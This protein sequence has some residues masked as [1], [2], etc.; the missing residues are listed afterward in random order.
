MKPQKRNRREEPVDQDASSRNIKRKEWAHRVKQIRN[1]EQIDDKGRECMFILMRPD[2]DDMVV[3]A[4]SYNYVKKLEF[5]HDEV[6]G[7]SINSLLS[8]I[9]VEVPC[10][11]CLSWNLVYDREPAT[12]HEKTLSVV[13][14]GVQVKIGDEVLVLACGMETNVLS[15][16]DVEIHQELQTIAASVA[17]QKPFMHWLICEYEESVGLSL[18][19]E[20]SAACVKNTFVSLVDS[21]VNSKEALRKHLSKSTVSYLDLAVVDKEVKL[22][23]QGKVDASET[24]STFS[25]LTHAHA[26]IDP[27][28][29]LSMGSIDHPDNCGK[30]CQFF[31]FSWKGCSKGFQCEY[32]HMP[33]ISNRQMKKQIWI[34]RQQNLRDDQRRFSCNNCSPITEH[35]EADQHSLSQHWQMRMNA[36]S[37]QSNMMQPMG[38]VMQ[39]MGHMMQ[40]LWNPQPMNMMMPYPAYGY[41]AYPIPHMQQ[42]QEADPCLKC[43]H[44]EKC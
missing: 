41:P 22:A 4:M 7:K 24:C 23:A 2:A 19:A 6:V 34:A 3:L 28:R 12:I 37:I 16:N 44:C 5:F 13:Q 21:S 9:Q 42:A 31:H 20:D 18:P 15:S 39:P 8:D 27:E 40:P 29:P 35:G 43:G 32:C 26:D 10:W 36:H 1:F 38:D 25:G 11:S 14:A 30:T 33:H 17:L